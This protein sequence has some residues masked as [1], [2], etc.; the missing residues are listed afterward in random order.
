MSPFCGA[1][2]T[3]VLD[4][5]WR[6]LQILN[7]QC[8][9]LFTVGRGIHVPWDSHLVQPADL[10]T[11]SMAAEPSLP[12]TCETL[13]GLETGSYHATTHI[14]RWGRRSTDWA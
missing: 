6:L 1:I 7:P 12:C 2:D 9:A 14:V 8:A 4:F 10:L 3:P 13:V 5:W 11:A